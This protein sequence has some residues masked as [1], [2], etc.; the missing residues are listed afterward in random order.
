MP[1]NQGRRRRDSTGNHPRIM[2]SQRMTRGRNQPLPTVSPSFLLGESIFVEE[3]DRSNHYFT[4]TF[5][6]GNALGLELTTGPTPISAPTPVVPHRSFLRSFSD[7][8]WTLF[9]SHSVF[10]K[11]FYFF[12]SRCW[13]SPVFLSCVQATTSVFIYSHGHP[14]FFICICCR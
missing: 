10:V 3:N 11:P 5:G 8:T 1:W 6:N 2:E 4:E 9:F 7:E 14:Q 13:I 12:Q